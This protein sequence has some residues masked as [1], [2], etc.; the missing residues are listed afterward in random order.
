MRENHVTERYG[1]LIIVKLLDPKCT[2]ACWRSYSVGRSVQ[3]SGE[4]RFL[5]TPGRSLWQNE[6][7]ENLDQSTFSSMMKFLL[8]WMQRCSS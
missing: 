5:F 7:L 1:R 6:L 3:K 4:D 2:I 8:V